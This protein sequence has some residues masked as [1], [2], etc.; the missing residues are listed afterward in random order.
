MVRGRDMLRHDHRR[1]DKLIQFAAH[2]LQGGQT[3]G[4]C[5]YPGYDGGFACHFGRVL[6]V[7]AGLLGHR[8]ST[9]Q[10][11]ICQAI[12]ARTVVR[13]SPPMHARHRA[14]MV[15]GSAGGERDS[16][17]FLLAHGH[18]PHQRFTVT[19][20]NY[21]GVSAAGSS[22]CGECA[23]WLCRYDTLLTLR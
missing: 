12:T 13:L 21:L 3:S 17:R 11:P 23:L 9:S 8:P 18:V 14:H 7:V 1:A 5:H 4:R 15:A 6:R 19:G 20:R 2:R 10:V 16:A 22:S